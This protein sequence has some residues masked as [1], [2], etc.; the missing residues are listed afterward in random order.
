M[1]S[2][3][4]VRGEDERSGACGVGLTFCDQGGATA[5]HQHHRGSRHL[6]CRNCQIFRIYSGSS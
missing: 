6:K 5:D 3:D 4:C 2:G 1:N